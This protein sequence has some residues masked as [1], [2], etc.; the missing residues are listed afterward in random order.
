[1]VRRHY[2][3]ISDSTLGG[4]I[5]KD[6][7]HQK[8]IIILLTWNTLN[9]ITERVIPNG[10]LHLHITKKRVAF[11]NIKTQGLM[12]AAKLSGASVAQR[13]GT[14]AAEREKNIE[15]KAQ[16][17]LTSSVSYGIGRGYSPEQIKISTMR[18]MLSRLM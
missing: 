14:F 6:R 8:G 5:I 4:K 2:R 18:L 12:P 16:S 15:K 11:D 7:P 10:R 3:P 17:K 9:I 13:E 1:M